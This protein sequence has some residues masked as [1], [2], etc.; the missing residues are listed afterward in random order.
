MVDNHGRVINYLRLAI[1]N[2]CNLRCR[3]CMPASG[4]DQ[5]RCEDIL[6]YEDLLR[7]VK[8]A[9][10]LGV[11]KVRV[12][13]GEP[14]VRKGVLGFLR[15]LAAIAQIEEI[16][17]TTNGLLLPEM[18]EELKSAGVVRLNVSLDSLQQQNF[19]D[20]TRGGS[21]SQVLK[22][23][24]VAEKA[25]LK[26]KI[27]MV[28]MRGINDNEIF[29]FANLSLNH[30]WSVRYIE[31]MPTIREEGW[32]GQLVSGREIL[33]QLN[34]RYNLISV[35]SGQYCGPAKPYQI[36]GAK[37]S[38]GIITPISDHFCGSCNRIRVTATGQA[39]SCLFSEEDVDLKPFLAGG[40]KELFQAL[41]Q[42]I[43]DKPSRHQ[44]QSEETMVSPFSMANVGG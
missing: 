13:G 43:D 40:E 21:L 24:D 22:G 33:A 16:A 8:T 19:R 37:G 6:P 5:Q 4:I 38:I 34:N 26:I 35:S 41:R 31:Y 32:Q 7:I 2:R 17:L 42:V 1:T 25:G 3:Y 44:M 12:T 30:P 18:A 28:V 14:L 39:K 15:Q 20:I 36:L 29:D 9:T 27:N 23:L 11:R 10:Q